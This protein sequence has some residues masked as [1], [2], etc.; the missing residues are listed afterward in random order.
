MFNKMNEYE[1]SKNEYSKEYQAS[2]VY[3]HIRT[4]GKPK[5]IELS[6]LCS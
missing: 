4:T 5:T 6:N 3:L 1:P 2:S